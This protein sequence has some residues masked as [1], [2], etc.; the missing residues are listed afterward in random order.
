M[1]VALASYRAFVRSHLRAS[2]LLG[3]VG[4]AVGL[5]VS[6]ATPVEYRATATVFAPATPARLA[7]EL[8]PFPVGWTPPPREWTQDTEAELIRSEVVLGG[9]AER[10]GEDWTV[11]SLSDRIHISVPT[12]AR[13]FSLTFTGRTAEGA[14]RGAETVAREYVRQRS[15]LIAERTRRVGGALRERRAALQEIIADAPAETDGVPERSGPSALPVDR[16]LRAQIRSQIAAIDKALTDAGATTANAADIVTHAR[17]PTAP[18][19]ANAEVAPLS[20]LMS[21]LVAGLGVGYLRRQQRRYVSDAYDVDDV[22]GLP[23]LAS[24]DAALVT[25]PDGHDTDEAVAVERASVDPVVGRLAAQLEPVLAG[26]SGRV[27]ILACCADSLAVS[28][29]RVLQRA[30]TVPSTAPAYDLDVVVAGGSSTADPH[31]DTAD[32]VLVLVEF[33]ATTRRALARAVRTL[34]VRHGSTK[35]VTTTGIVTLASA[36]PPGQSATPPGQSATPPRQSARPPGQS[37]R[38][39]KG[40]PG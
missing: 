27:V 15:A 23:V 7:L 2:V 6:W 14:R 33:G 20:G 10:L 40:T 39:T 24:V 19:R 26:G 37:G 29:A 36:T 1:T 16:A 13:V 22:A 34:G 17:L 28:F 38:T 18:T 12:S 25:A 3:A 30:L 11:A 8:Q 5:L 9:V 21:G 35:T 4:L 31:T 32:I